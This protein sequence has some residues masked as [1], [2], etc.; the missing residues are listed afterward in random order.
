MSSETHS[1]NAKVD[2][3]VYLEFQFILSNQIPKTSIN[4]GTEALLVEYIEKWKKKNKTEVI[5][6]GKN[7]KFNKS[8]S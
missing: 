3:Q 5:P 8:V 2:K 6:V 4:K 1:L 7:L